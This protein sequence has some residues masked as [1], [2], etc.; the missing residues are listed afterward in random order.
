MVLWGR[1]DQAL[2]IFTKNIIENKK[3]DLFNFGKHTRDFTYIDDIVDGI[4][5]IG[6]S[7]PKKKI[8]LGIPKLIHLT[9]SF[10]TKF[11]T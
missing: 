6:N 11:T 8:K 1:P 3:I 10:H 9:Q 2:F 7:I 5:K 4:I